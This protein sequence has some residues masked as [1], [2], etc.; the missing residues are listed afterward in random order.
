[1]EDVGVKITCQ[2]DV[3]ARGLAIVGRAVA[4][5]SPL[6]ITSNV[7][8]T[9]DEARDESGE[10]RVRLAA[11]NLDIAITCWIAGRVDEPGATSVP[12][13]LL[14]DFVNSLPPGDVAMRLNER[15]ETLNLRSGTYDANIKGIDADE[16]PPVPTV[17]GQESAADVITVDAELLDESI[18]QVAFAAAT[19]ETRPVLAGVLLSFHDDQLTLAAADGFRLAVRDLTVEGGTNL[20]D[21]IVPARTLMEVAR[22]IGDQEEPIEI[23]VTPNRNHILF[24]LKN[25]E[26]VS[27]LIEGNFPNFRQ[28]IPSKHTTRAIVG[29]KEFQ[30]ATK[31]ASFFARDVANIVRLQ[32]TPGEELTPGKI[33]VAAN[34]AEIGDASGDIPATVEGEAGHIAFNG[35][36]LSDVLAVVKTPQVALEV[37]TASSPGIIKP[38]GKDDYVCVIMPMFVSK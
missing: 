7:L 36:Y 16:F 20:G 26:L 35:K 18:G 31:I 15:S 9:S 10:R 22:I 8:I 27:R 2:Q 28:I 30:S 12:Y 38:V 25:V 33:T 24:R 32:M 29:A 11:T 1:M 34:A 13:R 5:R 19:D 4:A 17:D 14:S 21:I 37:T 3:L 6:P 23:A